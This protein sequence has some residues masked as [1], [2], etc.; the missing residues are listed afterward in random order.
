MTKR[1]SDA[2]GLVKSEPKSYDEICAAGLRKGKWTDEEEKYAA[3]IISHFENNLLPLCEQRESTIR[4]YLG[5]KLHC[6][7]MR[8]SKKFAGNNS[9]GKHFFCKK[10]EDGLNQSA[11]ALDRAKTE[12]EEMRL[13][14]VESVEREVEAASKRPKRIRIRN[15]RKKPKEDAD[16]LFDGLSDDDIGDLQSLLSDKV[17]GEDGDMGT[18][19]ITPYGC[20]MCTIAT[21]PCGSPNHNVFDCPLTPPSCPAPL[22]YEVEKFTLDSAERVCAPSTPEN[23]EPCETHKIS[24][25]H[26]N[27]AF[28]EPL[29]TPAATLNIPSTAMVGISPPFV[30]P[31]GYMVVCG[32]PHH[33]QQGAWMCGP[34]LTHNQVV[35]GQVPQGP[36]LKVE[37]ELDARLD[38]ILNSGEDSGYDFLDSI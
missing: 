24:R 1:P 17:K 8:I 11:E 38:D 26:L 32:P 3:T 5:K 6:D 36:S 10:Q 28:V 37:E 29:P 25:P 31:F 18:T 14:F 12:R 20:D 30:V 21:T 9:V 16:S 4:L 33:Q 22:P 7:P 13:A 2:A 23:I 15:R 34:P 35:K 27:G 19:I